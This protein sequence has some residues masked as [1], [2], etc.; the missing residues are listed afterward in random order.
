MV[1]RLD[2]AERYFGLHPAF[3][4]AFLFLR[5][6]SLSELA[7]GKHEIDG[8]RLFCTVSKGPGRKRAEAKLEAH[9]RYID[10]QF[11]IQGTDEMGWR[12]T[13]DCKLLD[14]DYDDQKDLIFFKDPPK[15][16]VKV[17][18]GSFAIF[19]PEV[20]HAPLVSNDTIHKVVI[21]VAVK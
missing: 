5:Q 6:K 18:S 7:P 16:W 13:A 9:R 20:A 2:Q 3:Q 17:P 11:V 14:A 1:D 21:K 4:K 15:Q 10:I 8:D 19:F 12:P